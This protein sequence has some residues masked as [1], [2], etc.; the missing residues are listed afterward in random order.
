M[1][2]DESWGVGILTPWIL[3]VEAPISEISMAQMTI[4]EPW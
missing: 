1:T 4:S 2:K 3:M